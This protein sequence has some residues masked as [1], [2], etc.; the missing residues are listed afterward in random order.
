MSTPDENAKRWASAA[1]AMQTGVGLEMEVNPNP[2]SPKHLRV[3]VNTALRDHAS[4]VNLLI[5]KGIFTEE[6]YMQAIVDGMEEEKA[7]Y[8]KRLSNTIYHGVKVDLL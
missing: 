8:E 3:G 7:T 6:E 4:L 1:H 2:T 5:S